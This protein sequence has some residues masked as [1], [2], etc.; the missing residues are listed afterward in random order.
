MRNTS[1]FQGQQQQQQPPPP[2]QQQYPG[3]PRQQHQGNHQNQP[4]HP[5]WNQFR[6]H[7]Q[8][9]AQLNCRLCSSPRHESKNCSNFPEGTRYDLNNQCLVNTCVGFQGYHC[10]PH[11]TN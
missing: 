10:G 11:K 3:P 2:P 6:G 4:N 1:D 8:G 5:N 7:G 9:Q